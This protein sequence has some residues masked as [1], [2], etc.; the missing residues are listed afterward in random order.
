MSG[1]I[2]VFLTTVDSEEKA[3]EIALNLVKLKLAACVSF[4]PVSSTYFWEEKIVHDKEFLL[5]I[6]T[7][8]GMIDK[9]VRWLKENHSY[10]VPELIK[11]DGKAYKPYFDWLI[12][13]LQS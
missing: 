13:Y 8:S 11:I 9:L 10:T 3:K 6:K 7:S 2:V 1:D 5:I 12:G 4:C